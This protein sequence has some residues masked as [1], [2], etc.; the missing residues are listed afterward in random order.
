M[1]APKSYC[2]ASN[3]TILFIEKYF[4][5]SRSFMQPWT[6]RDRASKL[7]QTSL[8]LSSSWPESQVET[9]GKK[10]LVF[11][12]KPLFADRFMRLFPVWKLDH[13]SKIVQ[14]INDRIRNR[15]RFLHF[16]D[17][18]LNCKTVL[19]LKVY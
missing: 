4:P 11:S 8:T 19:T 14:E 18:D 2:Q 17:L 1:A 5:H 6:S 10:S 7:H 3:H 12:I 15:I 13:L 16:Q 9:A